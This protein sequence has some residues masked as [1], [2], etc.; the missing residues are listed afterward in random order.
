MTTT[1][2]NEEKLSIVNQHIKN[3]DYSIY[4][5]E[6]EKLQ[7]EA[8]ATVDQ[9]ALAGVNARIAAVNVKRDALVAEQSLLTE[10]EA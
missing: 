4:G 7:I 1:L 6:L 5:I 3:L 8:T 2:T 10:P 9:D